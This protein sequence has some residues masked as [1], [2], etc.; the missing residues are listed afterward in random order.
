MSELIQ[1]SLLLVFI[2]YSYAMI[3]TLHEPRKIEIIY[4]E[5][6]PVNYNISPED[7]KFIDEQQSMMDAAAAIQSLFGVNNEEDTNGAR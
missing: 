6:Q 7:Q 3:R 2:L 1:L 4:P 5:P